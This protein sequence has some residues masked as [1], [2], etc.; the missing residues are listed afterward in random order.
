M[1][2]VYHATLAD[3]PGYLAR[4]DRALTFLDRATNQTTELTPE[5][6]GACHTLFPLPDAFAPAIVA[7]MRGC[8]DYQNCA[9]GS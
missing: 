2:T 5:I 1:T 3:Q 4:I 8:H 6:L 7:R 9:M